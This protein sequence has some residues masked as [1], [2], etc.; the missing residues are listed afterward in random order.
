MI[1]LSNL[2]FY[3]EHTGVAWYT[4]PGRFSRIL[5]A[6]DTSG[7]L[8]VGLRKKKVRLHRLIWEKINGKIPDGMQI[9][10]IDCNKTNN[11]L[12]NLRV[13]DRL[14]NA[15][16]KRP[17]LNASGYPGIQWCR[18]KKLW[19]S[20][21]RIGDRVV[22]NKCC[23]D[24]RVLYN[25]YRRA[26]EQFHGTDAVRHYP[27]EIDTSRF[28]VAKYEQRARGCVVC[29]S[30]RPWRS[31]YR[32]TVVHRNKSVFSSETEEAARSFAIELRKRLDNNL[33][34]STSEP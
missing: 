14:T 4:L 2:L 13:V 27:P 8:H 24:A 22:W 7:Y 25:R 30:P 16:N 29:R 23:N 26:K 17:P 32:W 5:T 34:G 33:C 10:H 11:A 21:V 19:V 3:N 18:K 31:E 12:I 6:K 1:Q 28:R 15:R 9:D 20:E